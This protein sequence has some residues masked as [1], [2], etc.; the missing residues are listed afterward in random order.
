MKNSK[1]P[2]WSQLS[3]KERAAYIRNAVAKGLSDVNDIRQDYNQFKNGGNTLKKLFLTH[4]DQSLKGYDR[5]NT[6][7]FR[8]L[9]TD[10]A[11]R[12]SSYDANALNSIG[13]KGYFQL[14]PQYRSAQ[15]SNPLQQFHEAYALMDSNMEYFKKNM[16]QQDLKRAQQLGIDIHGLSAGAWLGGAPNALK[17]LRGQGNPKDINNT[18]VLNYM[19]QFSQTPRTNAELRGYTPIVDNVTLPKGDIV[20]TDQILSN[21]LPKETGSEIVNPNTDKDNIKDDIR[22]EVQ[23]PEIT[24]IGHK[25][26][27]SFELP[28]QIEEIPTIKEI[29]SIPEFI[30][31][32]SAQIFTAYKEPEISPMQK[33]I[34]DEIITAE[35]RNK[36]GYNYKDTN[37]SDMVQQLQFL[38][39]MGNITANGGPISNSDYFA[40]MEKVAEQNNPIWNKQRAKE[41]L[42]LLSIDEEYL[43]ILNDNSYDYRGYYNKYP[44]SQAN[45]STHWTD[46]FKTAFHPTFSMESRYS[47][48]KS[49]YNPNGYLGGTWLGEEFLP[50][51]WQMNKQYAL[52]G[53]TEEDDYPEGYWENRREHTPVK[54]GYK[55]T[56]KD[57]KYW[58]KKNK[59]RAEAAEKFNKSA[60]LVIDALQQQANATPFTADQYHEAVEN[61]KQESLDKWNDYKKGLN[62]AI[63]ATELGLSGG[64]LLGA[65][66]NWRNWANAANTSKQVIANILQKAQLPM[67]VGGTLIDAYQTY[68][69]LQNED[70]FNTYY[71]AGSAG[72]GVAGAMGAADLFRNTRLNYP[73]IDRVLDAAGVIQNVGDFIKFGYDAVNGKALGGNLFGEGGDTQVVPEGSFADTTWHGNWL[74]N[75]KDQFNENLNSATPEQKGLFKQRNTKTIESQLNNLGTSK[76]YGVPENF[77]KT[78]PK[79]EEITSLKRKM[80][81]GGGEVRQNLEGDNSIY[82]NEYADDG[83]RMHEYTHAL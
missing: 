48:Q 58:E 1:I 47:G 38:R 25:P 52:G 14:M 37:I 60:G 59:Q 10:L 19:M 62:A 26:G 36:L 22:A 71:N 51:F 18:S 6:P 8:K 42:P 56:K 73:Y 27:I 30:E 75:R 20:T 31:Q 23:V 81:L 15:W 82:I 2:D 61:Q 13:A 33:A 7:Q 50:T 65:Y 40:L 80:I 16:T 49:Q 54:P 53:N 43:R 39:N 24:V 46:E 76:V 72:L 4:L 9:F 70:P 32:P 64:S 29:P 34:E 63:T 55:R 57:E 28:T 66:A 74:N 41:G 12:E 3:M 69:A 68:D 11:E 44:Q 17:A 5:Y 79:S 77:N 21:A 35:R 45:A 67:Q 83:V 78:V